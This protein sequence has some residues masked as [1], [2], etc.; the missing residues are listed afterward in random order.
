MNML[1]TNENIKGS[2]KDIKHLSTRNRT[3]KEPNGNF[4]R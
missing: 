3:Y 2:R 1:E 4:R